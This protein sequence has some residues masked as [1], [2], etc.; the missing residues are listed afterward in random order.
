[1]RRGLLIYAGLLLILLSVRFAPQLSFLPYLYMMIPLILIPEERL[2]FRNYRRGLLYG[3]LLL[4][5]FLIAPPSSCGVWVLNQLGV[6]VAEEIFFRG[7]LLPL[8][9]NLR[10]SFLFSLAHLINFPTLNSL[11]VFFPSLLFGFAYLR[12][13]SILA[14]VLLHFTANLFYASFVEEFPQLYR[15]LQRELTGS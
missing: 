12:S 3:S 8:F 11:L 14:P 4:P 2:G 7:F 9:G 10:T 15:I 6:A 5:L 13:G 1:M